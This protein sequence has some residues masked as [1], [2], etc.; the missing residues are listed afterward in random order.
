M[1]TKKDNGLSLDGAKAQRNEELYGKA[2]RGVSIRKLAKK[3]SIS[4]TR[5]YSIILEYERIKNYKHN[6]GKLPTR[7]IRSLVKGEVVS[8]EHAKMIGLDKLLET[9]QVGPIT[10]ARIITGYY[11]K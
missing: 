2:S 10:A 5:V 1:K 4:R 6:Y 3:Y 9:K 11:D 8:L 7:Y